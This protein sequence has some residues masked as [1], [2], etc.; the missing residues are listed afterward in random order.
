MS[1]AKA[2]GRAAKRA[3]IRQL[4]AAPKNIV[5]GLAASA[6][7]RGVS[8][9]VEK[10]QGNANAQQSGKG[11][12]RGGFAS[13]GTLAFDDHVGMTGEQFGRPVRGKWWRRRRRV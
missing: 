12:Q 6:A 4:K 13:F 1:L 9:V 7:E 5:K 11:H 10:L 3:A 8:K 2:G